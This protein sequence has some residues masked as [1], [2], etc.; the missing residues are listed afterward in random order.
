MLLSLKPSGSDL[1]A[2]SGAQDSAFNWGQDW[3]CNCR[4]QCKTEMFKILK[5][6]KTAR[7]EH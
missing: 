1:W 4:A 2:L 5:N 6:F 3:F 7:A